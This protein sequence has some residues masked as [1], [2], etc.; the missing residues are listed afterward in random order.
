MTWKI[1]SNRGYTRLATAVLLFLAVLRLAFPPVASAHVKWFASYDVRTR[2]MPIA[3]V[4]TLAFFVIFAGFILLLFM[5]FLADSWVAKRWPGLKAAGSSFVEF[6]EK[7][8][9]MG[10]GAFLLCMWTIGL[11]ILTPELHTSAPW[12]FTVQF[13]SALFL[14]WRRTCVLSAVGICVLYFYAVTQY[15]LFHMLDYVYFLGI[16]VFL[17]G[18]SIAR[19]SQIRVTAI[20]GCLAFSIMWTAIEKFVYPQ[21]TEQVLLKHGH[22]AMGM[23]YGLFVVVAGFVEFTLAFYLAT[24]RGMLRLGTLVLLIVFIAAMPEFG[25]RDVVGHLPLI[26]ILGVPLVGGNSALQRF[27]RLP[28]RGTVVNAGAACLLYTLSLSLF[29]LTYYGVQWLEYPPVARY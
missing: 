7:W 3:R 25:R 23:P 19:L 15:G 27:W 10:M 14:G 12:V 13:F 2:P 26:A 24:G 20:T 16:A 22:M 21:W 5:G 17:A 9:R 1:G 29:F 11:D 6:H 18:V 8:V 4:G 28:G